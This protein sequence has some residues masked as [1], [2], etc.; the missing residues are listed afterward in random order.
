MAGAEGG[1]TAVVIPPWAR[2]DAEWASA[3]HLLT[4]PLL[5][6][7]DVMDHVDFVRCHINVPRLLR[8]S[9]PWSSGERAML[10]AACD[11]FNGGGKVGLSELVWS[12]DDGNLRRV[13]EA[14]E[15]RRR[16]RG[17]PL[18]EEETP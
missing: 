16:W 6:R 8:V 4:S 5:V 18:A 10:R 14:V 15:I 7:K 2:A 3:L 17:W 11:L 9:T 12:L 13:L 1:A